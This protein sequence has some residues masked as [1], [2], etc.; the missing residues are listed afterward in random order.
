[1]YKIIMNGRTP[2]FFLIIKHTMAEALKIG[3]LYLL[4]ELFAHTFVILGFFH[5]A[6]AVAVLLFKPCLYCFYYL[7][8]GIESYFHLFVPFRFFGA[9]TQCG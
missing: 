9:L 4:S 3:I 6:G 7:L 5:A 8:I 2:L 1:M